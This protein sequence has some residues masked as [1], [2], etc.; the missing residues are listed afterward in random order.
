VSGLQRN[1]ASLLNDSQTACERSI[2]APGHG[3]LGNIVGAPR[4]LES[5]LPLPAESC[6]SWVSDH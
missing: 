4:I 6:R 3:P 2:V 5:T 1:E